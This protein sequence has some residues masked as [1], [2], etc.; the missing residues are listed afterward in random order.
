M[1]CIFSEGGRLISI[2]PSPASPYGHLYEQK[3]CLCKQFIHGILYDTYYNT[4][5]FI[6]LQ[7]IFKGTRVQIVNNK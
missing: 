1:V 7:Q 6:K 4:E 2:G 5:H 3:Q